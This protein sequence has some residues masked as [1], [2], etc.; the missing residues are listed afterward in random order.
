MEEPREEWK[1]DYGRLWNL[2]GLQHTR[3]QTWNGVFLGVN[4]ALLAGLAIAEKAGQRGSVLGSA[5]A[6]LVGVAVCFLWLAVNK[7]QDLDEEV[8]YAQLNELERLLRKTGVKPSLDARVFFHEPDE[9]LPAYLEE[10]LGGERESCYNKISVRGL[11]TVLPVLFGAVYAAIWEVAM[12]KP[13]SQGTEHALLA[14]EGAALA[15]F[16]L[17]GAIWWLLTWSQKRKLTKRPKKG[18][19]S[20]PARS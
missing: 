3:R 4:T 11:L 13:T 14:L 19:C 18:N 6:S 7:R 9:P 16:V 1:E 8:R 20:G 10:R 5:L 15:P 17:L 12:F 2:M